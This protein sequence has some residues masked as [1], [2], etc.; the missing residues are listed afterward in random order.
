MKFSLKNKDLE[1]NMSCILSHSKR[2]EVFCLRQLRLSSI[3][4]AVELSGSH[5]DE[6]W[7][8]M[9]DHHPQP[10]TIWP[11]VQ[12]NIYSKFSGLCTSILH[13]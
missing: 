6:E 1:K 10:V 5:L 9:Y 2:A 7:R 13:Q 8:F 11:G 4:Q 3:H 12:I